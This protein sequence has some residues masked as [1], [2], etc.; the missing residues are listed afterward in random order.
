MYI[1]G[2]N[3]NVSRNVFIIIIIII[4]III[5]LYVANWNS[6]TFQID[7]FLGGLGEVLVIWKGLHEMSLSASNCR[8]E[9]EGILYPCR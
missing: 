8:E 5:L 4:I 7:I 1:I 2:H 9:E 6:S 3:L